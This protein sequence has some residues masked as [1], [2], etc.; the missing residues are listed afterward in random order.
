MEVT[1]AFGVLAIS[2]FVQHILGQQ[3]CYCSR[4]DCSCT[5]STSDGLNGDMIAPGNPPLGSRDFL[6]PS[7][8]YES[9]STDAKPVR[10]ANR[11]QYIW[12]GASMI[13]SS[14]NAIVLVRTAVA[15]LPSCCCPTFCRGHTLHSA[16]VSRCHDVQG[17]QEGIADPDL[18]SDGTPNPSVTLLYK[19]NS[20]CGASRLATDVSD[21]CGSGSHLGQTVCVIR[22]V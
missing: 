20:T 4:N 12:V 19:W 8:D 6:T 9:P 18:G 14:S 21:A 22:H 5:N 11:Q 16:R 10:A 1:L 3:S 17:G 13:S 7:G 2:F 15:W